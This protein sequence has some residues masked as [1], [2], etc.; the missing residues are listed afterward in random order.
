MKKILVAVIAVLIIIGVGGVFFTKSQVKS[1]IQNI[2][3]NVVGNMQGVEITKDEMKQSLTQTDGSVEITIKGDEFKKSFGDRFETFFKGVLSADTINT[4]KQNLSSGGNIADIHVK[5]DYS[6]SH[7]PLG[8]ANGFTSNGKITF[9][10]KDI[11]DGLKEIFGTDAPI[12]L[13]INQGLMSRHT[14]VKFVDIN[15]DNKGKVAG[16][17]FG[18]DASNDNQ[19]SKAGLRIAD[20]NILDKSTQIKIGGVDIN[21]NFDKPLNGNNINL[22]DLV[23]SD[24]SDDMSIKDVSIS[25]SLGVIKLS[26]ITSKGTQKVDGDMIVSGGEMNIKTL[27]F[28]KYSLKNANLDL[29]VKLPEKAMRELYTNIDDATTAKIEK[30]NKDMF[31]NLVLDVKN[32]SIQ[33]PNDEK[34]SLTFNIKATGFDEVKEIPLMVLNGD[35]QTTGTLQDLANGF[36]DPQLSG[37]ATLY[38][39]IVKAQTMP[40]GKGYKATF[41]F[42]SITNKAK[43][44]NQE[45]DLN[46]PF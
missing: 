6:V 37:M 38:D 7:S 39:A 34:I 19:I 33:T 35:I 43:F 9:L 15:V 20:I 14:D 17:V 25:S 12:L 32:F 31:K 41:G 10:D 30:Y 16:L 23:F 22:V 29:Y 28:N 26:D 8:V 45:V 21:Y 44:N 5:Y 4:A 24:I 36:N 40:N 2:T 3:Q 13:D 1:Q 11:A 18:F 46:N 27:S 42:D